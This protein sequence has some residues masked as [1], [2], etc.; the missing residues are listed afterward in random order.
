MFYPV[1]F[2]SLAIYFALFLIFQLNYFF[3]WET[4]FVLWLGSV[5]ASSR[6]LFFFLNA[7]W[8]SK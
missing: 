4:F 8:K 7:S 2:L 6:E 1:P 5:K 3:M